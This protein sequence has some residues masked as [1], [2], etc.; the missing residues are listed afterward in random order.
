LCN[1]DLYGD[2]WWKSEVRFSDW[3]NVKC[4]YS[5]NAIVDWWYNGK[6]S[7]YFRYES[8]NEINKRLQ[9]GDTLRIGIDYYGLFPISKQFIPTPLIEKY[10]NDLLNGK[11]IVAKVHVEDGQ[12]VWNI[13]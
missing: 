4:D 9:R 7:K 12:V 6:G 13:Y 1:V 2:G 10:G 8:L 3:R 5:T 11:V